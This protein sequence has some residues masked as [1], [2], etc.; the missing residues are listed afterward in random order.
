M[1]PPAKKLLADK[2]AAAGLCR[3]MVMTPVILGF[4]VRG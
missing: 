4:L 2:A 3:A 1:H